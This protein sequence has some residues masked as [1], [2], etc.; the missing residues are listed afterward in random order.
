MRRRIHVW[1]S[2]TF[3]PVEEKPPPPKRKTSTSTALLLL[4]LL[5]T[6]Q[7]WPCGL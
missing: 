4:L 1:P 2:S 6:W 5:L 7:R 3:N